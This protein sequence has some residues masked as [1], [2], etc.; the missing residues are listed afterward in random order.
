[1]GVAFYP[2]QRVAVGGTEIPIVQSA[3]AAFEIPKKAIYKFG[4]YTAVANIVTEAPSATFQFSYILSK[5]SNT[6]NTLG[7]SQLQSSLLD[8]TAGKTC[9]LGGAGTFTLT[10]AFLTSFSVEGSVGDVV[11]CSA[12]FEGT[13]A[14]FSPGT[15]TVPINQSS[16]SVEIVSPDVITANI[17]GGSFACR[18]FTFSIDIP[19]EKI[20]KFGTF[21]PHATIPNRAPTAKIEAE[22]I[23][24]D[25]GP[26]INGNNLSQK[27]NSSINC[28]GVTYSL[29]NAKI[30]SYSAD[31]SIDGPATAKIT[32][33][34]E[35]ENLSDVSIGG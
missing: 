27:Y 4:Q 3:S 15:A 24:G 28:G 20:F 26:S 22:I 23:L 14:T 8:F 17:A 33:E 16:S 32:L 29:T 21:T 35:L 12:S 34:Q 1:M 5:S 2:A 10:K 31:A 7:V 11:N 19:R 25:G 13:E 9:V 30:S 18:S 6:A